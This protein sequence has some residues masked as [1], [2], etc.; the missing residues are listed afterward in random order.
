MH[1]FGLEECRHYQR[2]S[3]EAE[4]ALSLNPLEAW[5]THARAHCYEMA[6][7]HLGEFF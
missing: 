5:A 4:R 6:G 2:A 1:A 3:A 7:D